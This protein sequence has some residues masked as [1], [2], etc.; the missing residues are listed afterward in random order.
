MQ[1]FSV[2]T[3]GCKVNQYDGNAIATLLRRAGWVQVPPGEPADLTVVNTCCV[4]ASAMRKTRQ[5]IRRVIRKSP[6][7]AA[8]VFGCYSDYDAERI[9][10]LL[11]SH[12]LPP[13]RVMIAGHH[14]GLCGRLE[15]FLLRLAEPICPAGQTA[16][17]GS[18]QCV[19]TAYLASET[20]I[21]GPS[22]IKARRNRLVK[23]NVSPADRLHQIDRFEAHQRAF[24]KVQDGCDAFCSYCIVPYTRP[25][26]W[27]KDID[28]IETECRNLVAGG[29]REIV[30]AGIFLGAFGRSGAIRRKWAKTN[31]SPL[32]RLVTR[33]AGIEGLWRV[34]LS[35]LEPGDLSDE[36][37][38]VFAECPNVA[39]HFHLPLQ[40]G[41]QR[42]LQRMNRQYTIR[43]YRDTIDRLRDAIDSPAIT[44]DVIVGF[45]GE[46]DDDFTATLDLAR[47]AGFA[48]IHAF[49][50][51]PIEPTVAWN[52]RDERPPPNVVRQR[53]A[54][55]A[56]LERE[57][58]DDYA[59]RFVNH[60]TEGIVESAR[61]GREN[62]RQAL[63]DR[64]L[65]VSF[66]IPE[67]CQKDLTGEVV[68]LRIEEL[69]PQGLRGRLL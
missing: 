4:T 15:Q 62:S 49:P 46:S 23:Q 31:S 30:L 61:T 25:H 27:S 53:I 9:L 63:T 21:S 10:R 66:D 56:K 40:S 33:I 1:R 68:R 47:Y 52:W 19:D 12:D 69:S 39:P 29:Y 36:L 48:K 55:L 14:E 50:F 16:H 37:L 59:R 17:R 51:S 6:G 44:T 58:A 54:L 42:I 3:L 34:R 13:D 7:A 20:N 57:L 22:N 8:L 64:Y 60:Q 5:A 18:D 28:S 43:Q 65:R 26:V 35:S 38:E 32:G 24:V 41:S 67:N 11:L 45:P 2:T